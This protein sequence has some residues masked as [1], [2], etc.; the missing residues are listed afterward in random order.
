[1]L[2]NDSD[3]CSV[4]QAKD[5]FGENVMETHSVRFKENDKDMDKSQ[6]EEQIGMSDRVLTMCAF[7]E[8][9]L[10]GAVQ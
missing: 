1:M 8:G 4:L 2:L 3:L 7:Q 10:P 5:F 6:L 9:T